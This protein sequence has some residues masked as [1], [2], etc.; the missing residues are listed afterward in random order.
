M[1]TDNP[2]DVYLDDGAVVFSE[3]G[4]YYIELSRCDTP[5]KLIAWLYHLTEKTWVT[6]EMIHEFLRIVSRECGVAV[7]PLP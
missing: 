4:D 6:S 7:H 3:G 2:K 5:E 1:S